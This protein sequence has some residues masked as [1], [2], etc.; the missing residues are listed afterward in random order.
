MATYGPGSRRNPKQSSVS[1][2]SRAQSGGAL[3]P[4][5]AARRARRPAARAA[6]RRRPSCATPS[7]VARTSSPASASSPSACCSAWRSTSTWPARWAVGS[8]RS[9][10][11]SPGSAG[12]SCPSRWSAS[13]PR[14]SRKGRAMRRFRLALGWGLAG[15]S[16]LGLLHVV[17]GPREDHGQLRRLRHAPAAGSA[18][19][20]ANRCASLLADAGAIVVLV[21]LCIGGVLLITGVHRCGRSVAH[22]QRASVPSRCRSARPHVGAH[23][24]RQHVTTLRS[25]R[26]TGDYER[27]GAQRCTTRRSDDDVWAD[28]A[29]QAQ[30]RPRKLPPTGRSM[31]GPASSPSWSSGPARSAGQWVLPPAIY[32]AAQRVA[33]HQQGRGR[34]ARAHAGRRR[35]TRTASRP[36]CSARRSA[37][38]SP[39]TSS[40]SARASRSPGSPAST[41]TSRTRWPP[42]TCASWRPSRAARRSASRCP[43]T[44]AS[45]S[46]SA[47]S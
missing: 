18:R 1:G 36:T 5:P 9:S 39:A 38:P 44:P 47:T 40:S 34:G 43:T 4:A 45:W 8:R 11:G 28:A 41:A 35:S 21:A 42:P 24:V 3:V 22:R 26:E 46:A 20:S 32:L 33:D 13:G 12:S 2:S 19:S 10:A 27:P 31:P 17:R 23:G 16:L 6:A 14:W 29:A 25:D 7:R 37:P 30:A 15:L